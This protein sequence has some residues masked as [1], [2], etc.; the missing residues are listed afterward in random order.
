MNVYVTGAAT[1]V[2]GLVLPIVVALITRPSTSGSVKSALHGALAGVLSGA[3]AYLADPHPDFGPA[4]VV[5][6]LTGL[7]GTAFYRKVLKKYPWFAAV[8]N[9]FVRE[10][11]TRLHTEDTAAG[12][13]EKV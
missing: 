9:A 2:V 7:T 11:A 1:V 10:A 4:F 6:V 13:P 3:G 5:T 12:R 8:Q